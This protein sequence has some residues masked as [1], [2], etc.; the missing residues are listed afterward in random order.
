M[1]IKTV[2]LAGGYGTRI[3]DVT[4]DIPKPMI[5]IGNYPILWHV[6]KHYS[7]YGI[8]DFVLCLGYKSEIIKDYF[9]NYLV[10]QNDFSLN[11][12][13]QDIQYHTNN[14]SEE[15]TITF[16]ETGLNSQ[17]GAR[18]FRVKR[19]IENEDRFM[20]TYGDGVG[21]IDIDEL[22]RFHKSHGKLMTVTG[23]HPPGRFGELDIEGNQVI[24]FNE[25]PQ[26]TEG[27]ISA[28]FF[29]C[30]RGVLDYLNSDENLIL[31]RDPIENLVKDQQLM[32]YKHPGFWHPM[33]TSRD[34][35]LLNKLWQE[36][37]APWKIY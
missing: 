17:T 7:C 32:V 10:R 11:L 19:Y 23:A 22:L 15:W 14:L 24:G 21:N 36:K 26:T 2:I 6:M 8:K 31:E 30:E 37:Q 27:W 29:V 28:G 4:S 16:S 25:K 5:P 34:Y 33:D 1:G 20:L 13:T 9:S 35:N 12:T 18:V 3:R